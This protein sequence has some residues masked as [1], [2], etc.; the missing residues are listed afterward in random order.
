MSQQTL[1]ITFD[2]HQVAVSTNISTILAELEANFQN[3]LA[4]GSPKKTAGKFWVWQV[5]GGYLL[6]ENGDPLAQAKTTSLIGRRLRDEIVLRFIQARPNLLWLHAGA[7]ARQGQAVII[8]GPSGHGKSTL[9]THLCAG[10]WF[11]LSDD[12]VPLEPN[13]GRAFPFPET[14]MVRRHSG[15]PISAEYLALLNKTS[16]SLKA[17]AVCQQAVP[18]KAVILPGYSPNEET[19]LEPCSP[20]AATLELIQNTQNFVDHREAAVRYLCRLIEQMPVFRLFYSDGKQAAALINQNWSF[21]S[22]APQPGQ[23]VGLA[24]ASV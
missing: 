21:L 9:V 12:V 22:A 18:V 5:D 6:L 3:M 8:A 2:R 16:I 1:Y 15:R 23:G 17:G 24:A 4:A 14:P 11:Y 13:L 7:A 19:R 10:G 20:G